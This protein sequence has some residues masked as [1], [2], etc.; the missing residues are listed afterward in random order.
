MGIFDTVSS[1]APNSSI[2]PDFTND[3]KELALNIPNFMPSVEEIVHFVAADEYRENFS[4]TT[5]DSAS[6]GMQVMGQ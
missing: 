1:F 2:S 6:N 4:L 3:V 5:I